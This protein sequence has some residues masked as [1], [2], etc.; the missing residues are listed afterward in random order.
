[1][2][3]RDFL[4]GF[5]GQSGR[6]RRRGDRMRR[7]DLLIG[8][9]LSVAAASLPPQTRAADAIKRVAILMG[10]ADDKNGQSRVAAF[11]L[12]LRELGW[13]EG[14][15]IHYEVRWGAGDA[16]LTRDYAK[17]LVALNPDLI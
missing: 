11:Q 1:M 14:R 15:N 4:A 6:A 9:G 3:R 17:E 2:R 13:E 12:G 8:T 10:V 16:A 7:R 5:A